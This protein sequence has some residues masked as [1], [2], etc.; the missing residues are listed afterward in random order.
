MSDARSWTA[1]TQEQARLT[2]VRM[3][4]EQGFSPSDAAVAVGVHPE[5]VRR[6]VRRARSGGAAA[7]GARRRGRPAGQSGLLTTA[8]QRVLVAA[9]EGGR[10][11]QY[12]LAQLLWTRQAVADL[13]KARFG[14][15]PALRTVSTWLADWGFTAKKPVWRV[16]SQSEE[17]VRVFQTVTYP[18]LAARAKR[19]G[20]EIWFLDESGVRVDAVRGRGYAKRGSRAVAQKPARRAGVN[21]IQAATR[22]G[23]HAFSCFEGSADRALVVEFLTR[24]ADR[25]P[26]KIIVV[27]DNHT[28]HRGAPIDAFLKERDGAV[29]LVYLPT[30]APELNPVEF[31]NNDLKGLLE[32]APDRPTTTHALLV[33]VRRTLMR[34]NRTRGRVASWFRAKELAYITNTH[35]V[36]DHR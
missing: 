30:Y 31:G 11:D 2:A 28:I 24:L 33:A 35:A 1:E 27:L 3:V 13:A 29:E 10:P 36:L 17:A 19:E 18:L 34:L 12:M 22:N 25:A 23:R 20:A 21:V 26:S 4:S 15:T 5:T 14:V 32:T 9:I 16:M 6:W 8:Q 7:L